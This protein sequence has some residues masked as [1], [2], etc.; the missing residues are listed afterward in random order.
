VLREMLV[1]AAGHRDYSL[2]GSSVRVSMFPNRIEVASPGG[3]PV[4]APLE[5]LMQASHARNRMLMRLLWQV[6]FCEAF[7]LGLRTI[8]DTM[9]R[10]GLPEPAF[11]T[12]AANFFVSITG[13]QITGL[14][15]EIAERLTEPQLVLLRALVRQGSL[16]PR[17]AG[18]L[19]P[20]R[21]D[22]SIR[23]DLNSLVEMGVVVRMGETRAV[24]YRLANDIPRLP[25]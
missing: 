25:I 8:M 18:A 5:G 20:Q 15:M 4:A 10:E 17:Q 11:D 3:P 2:S 16:N 6:R 12:A 7:G 19:L 1:N 9:A 23:N 14:T 21:S 24:S 22:R 13:H